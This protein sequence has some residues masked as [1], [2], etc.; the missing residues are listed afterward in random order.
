[1]RA[2]ALALSSVSSVGLSREE[3]EL[4]A[5]IGAV[6]INS[7][8]QALLLEEGEREELLTKGVGGTT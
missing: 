1:M 6:V 8:F 4:V 7:V 3:E 2:R 5:T